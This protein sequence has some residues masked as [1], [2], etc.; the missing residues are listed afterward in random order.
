M[1]IA[2]IQKINR[3]PDGNRHP[4]G[5]MVKWLG[6]FLSVFL[7]WVFMCIVA[8]WIEKSPAVKPLAEFIEDTGIDASALYYTE[9]EEA[10]EAELNMRHTMKYLPQGR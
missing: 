7:V 9:V 5:V 2:A 6:F 10:S 4:S 3:V 8:P 1:D